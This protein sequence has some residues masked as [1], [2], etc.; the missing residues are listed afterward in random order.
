MTPNKLT[1]LCS[2][3]RTA[4]VEFYLLWRLLENHRATTS[5]T[6]PDLSIPDNS[7][8]CWA[9]MTRLSPGWR[10][11]PGMLL[12]FQLSYVDCMKESVPRVKLSYK[13]RHMQLLLIRWQLNTLRL[14]SYMSE[15]LGNKCVCL[16]LGPC[17]S[18][19]FKINSWRNCEVNKLCIWSKH[20]A[21]HMI[22]YNVA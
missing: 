7:P 13:G 21:L 4:V 10:R 18:T 22:D 8:F 20:S 9:R 17:I 6:C 15:L 16:T 11:L 19:T 3:H 1:R 14:W 12:L 2:L 5:E